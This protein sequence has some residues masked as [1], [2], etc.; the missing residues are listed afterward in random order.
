M[1]YCV[2]V[3]VYVYIYMSVY[4]YLHHLYYVEEVS[5]NST[6]IRQQCHVLSHIDVHI[7]YSPGKNIK[8]R[9]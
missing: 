3:K 4:V 8:P 6:D 2:H 9:N 7:N 1:F 5:A